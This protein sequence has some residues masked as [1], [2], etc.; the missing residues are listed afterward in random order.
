MDLT[1]L[2]TEQLLVL[3][4]RFELQ[5]ETLN[6]DINN[7]YVELNE[8]P[9]EEI[10]WLAPI[11]SVEEILPTEEVKTIKEASNKKSK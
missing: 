9:K 7:M 10:F 1:T 6:T 4:K 11:Q 2:S 3:T 5:R 8:R